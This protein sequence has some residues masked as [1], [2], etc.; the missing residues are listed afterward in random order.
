[1][2][3]EIERKF[4]PVDESWRGMAERSISM[5]QVYLGGDGVSI[6]VRIANDLASINIKQK[7]LGNQRA[8]FEYEIPLADAHDLAALSSGLQI[9]KTRHIVLF[10]G[11]EWEVDEFHGDNQ[12]LV[13]AEIELEEEEEV[14]EAPPWLG[15]EVSNDP[16]FFNASLA[17]DPYS[18]WEKT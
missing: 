7:R 12:G 2:A 5:Q 9:A 10:A 8:E 14:F 18:E 13:V 3:I 4:L 6:R 1:M 11:M 15:P 16:R 17:L